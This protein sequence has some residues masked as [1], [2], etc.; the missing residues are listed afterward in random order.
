MVRVRC[1]PPYLR[2]W[3]GWPNLTPRELAP[4]QLVGLGEIEPVLSLVIA[5]EPDAVRVSELG[6]VGDHT[7]ELAHFRVPAVED[8]DRSL[9]VVRQVEHVG[10]KNAAVRCLGKK[11]HSFKPFDGRNDLEFRRQ[12]ERK[13]LARL[14]RDL[15]RR[16]G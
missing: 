1:Q 16:E 8:I 3:V 12:V 6:H 9:F 14:Q 2:I 15:V 7:R 4:R 5:P 10:N 11:A 13:G